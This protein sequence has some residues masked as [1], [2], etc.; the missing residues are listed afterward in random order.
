[1]LKKFDSTIWF[2]IEIIGFMILVMVTPMKI[3]DAT[4]KDIIM[5]I[6]LVVIPGIIGLIKEKKRSKNIK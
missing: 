6:I 1:M 3:Q 4:I 2:G 5:A